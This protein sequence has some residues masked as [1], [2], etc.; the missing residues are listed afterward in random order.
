MTAITS[1]SARLQAAPRQQLAELVDL[2]G[3]LAA[4]CDRAE[5]N[6]GVA[7][8]ELLAIGGRLRT[9]GLGLLD[10]AGLEPVPA[11]ADRLRQ[12]EAKNVLFDEDGPDVPSRLA[13]PSCSWRTV[14]LVQ[15]AHDRAFHPDVVGL[16]R[17]QQLQ[18]Y[19]LHLAKLA[20][21]L[22]LAGNRADARTDWTAGRVADVLIFSVKLATVANFRLPQTPLADGA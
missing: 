7:R 4:W 15:A 2:S 16:P 18:H 5:H 20:R 1:I 10:D 13:Q 11:Y 21:Y 12:I 9:L 3:L 8:D 14:Q 6:E 22:Q 19:A 17:V